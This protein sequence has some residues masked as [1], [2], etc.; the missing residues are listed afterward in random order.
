MSYW[1]Y[2]NRIGLQ[3]ASLERMLAAAVAALAVVVA[4]G[5]Q[6]GTQMSGKM[7]AQTGA[8][9]APRAA[10][11]TRV[12]VSRPAQAPRSLGV[13]AP[14]AASTSVV[15][16]ASA[17]SQGQ[18]R[19]MPLELPEAAP[20]APS[21]TDLGDDDP[22]ARTPIQDLSGMAR[23]E[24]QE[25]AGLPM[26]AA[27]PPVSPALAPAPAPALASPADVTSSSSA[28]AADPRPLQGHPLGPPPAPPM[29]GAETGFSNSER[30]EVPAALRDRYRNVAAH[31]SVTVLAVRVSHLGRALQVEVLVPSANAL[32]D[33]GYILGMAQLQLGPIDPPLQPGESRWIDVPINNNPNSVLP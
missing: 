16:A 4:G 23:Q 15:S 18:R 11:G 5:A 8:R 2:R 31:G 10:P 19:V 29:S 9:E 12:A 7:S 1:L 17:R 24:A 3:P 6:L 32:T 25:A 27:A 13:K 26:L 30:Q 21:A 22:L 28:P 14:A 33:V 20:L